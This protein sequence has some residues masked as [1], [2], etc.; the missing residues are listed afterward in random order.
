MILD[1][2]DDDLGDAFLG[3]CAKLAEV[4][5]FSKA[6]PPNV[7]DVTNAL[8]RR[9]TMDALGLLTDLLKDGMQPVQVM[10]VLVWI[11]GKSRPRLS[12]QKFK[13]GLLALE[14]ADLNIKRSR[15]KPDHALEVVVVKLGSLLAPTHLE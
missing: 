15:L 10:G 3:K 12:P 5:S 6:A 7:F 13:E 14:E 11:W 1:S 9:Q 8:S 2:D 4:T